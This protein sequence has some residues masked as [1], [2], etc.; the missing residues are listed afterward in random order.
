MGLIPASLLQYEILMSEMAHFR[1]GQALH[2]VLQ[3]R[4]FPESGSALTL[5]IVAEPGH[6]N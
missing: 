3:C 5:S 1:P 6:S 4:L 2:W